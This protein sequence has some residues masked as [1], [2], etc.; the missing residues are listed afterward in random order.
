MPREVETMSG[1]KKAKR[2]GASTEACC[3]SDCCGPGAGCCGMPAAGCCTV[4]AVVSV[5]ERG[6][7]VLPKEVRETF[8]LKGGDKLAV[9]AW[10]RQ[11]EPCC[12]MLLKVDALADAVR[13]AYGPMLKEIIR[14]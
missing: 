2:E 10:T 4:E 1:S 8:H 7:M 9:A 6:Q 14:G 5:D 12:L 3:G 13:T 11:D